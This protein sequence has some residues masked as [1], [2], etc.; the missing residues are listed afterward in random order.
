MQ[1]KLVSQQTGEANTWISLLLVLTLTHYFSYS[2]VAVCFVKIK[3]SF[4][5]CLICVLHVSFYSYE[6]L[7]GPMFLH[8]YRKRNK[9][10]IYKISCFFWHCRPIWGCF[11]LFIPFEN[12]RKPELFRPITWNLVYLHCLYQL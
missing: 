1:K 10:I 3:F 2:N 6:K 4:W 9:K 12:K 7:F 11:S 8:S 5:N